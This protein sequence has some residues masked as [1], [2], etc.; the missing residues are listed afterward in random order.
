ML[1]IIQ[2]LAAIQIG[3]AV[4][5]LLGPRH[6]LRLGSSAIA[7]A[8]SLVAIFT[9]SWVYLAVGTAIFLATMG[10]RPSTATVG[11]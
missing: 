10:I 1:Y 3:I 5:V 6:A 8:L 7:I 9:G 4:G 11:G 2:I